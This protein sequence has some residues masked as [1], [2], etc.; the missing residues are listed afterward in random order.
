MATQ[1][2]PVAEKTI[3]EEVE[4]P[5]RR[6]YSLRHDA[7]LVLVTLI[8]GSTFLIVK[9]AVRLSGPFTYLTLSYGVGSLLLAFIFHRR[10]LHS[11]LG[12]SLIY[13]YCGCRIY[14]IS[15]DLGAT[16]SKWH[17]S[18]SHLRPGTNVGSAIRPIAGR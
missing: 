16:G 15:Y 8:W 13:G 2:A 7:L 6:S 5:Q 1:L 18:G 11:S 4:K 3:T 17:A 9:N 12:I 10:L 14:S